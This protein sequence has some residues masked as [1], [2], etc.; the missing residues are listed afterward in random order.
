MGESSAEVELT[1]S[2]WGNAGL[3][4]FAGNPDSDAQRPA[5]RDSKYSRFFL[6]RHRQG[7]DAAA[8]S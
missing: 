2:F 3:N 5:P 8:R 4:D 6:R 1:N 7:D